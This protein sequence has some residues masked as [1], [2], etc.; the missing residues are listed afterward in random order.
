MIISLQSLKGGTGKSTIS[1]NLGIQ[2]LVSGKKVLA[3]DLDP[4]SSLTDFLLRDVD[5]ESISQ[6]NSFH[7]LS[8]RLEASD[9]IFKTETGIDAIPATP[10]LHKI[11]M[12]MNG[13]PG[14]LLRYK[15][16]LD[17]LGYDIV[18]IDTPPSLSY[19][20]RAGLYSADNVIVPVNYDRW[21]IQGLGLMQDEIKKAEKTKNTKM[22]FLAVP[23]MA[24]KKES[25]NL[26]ELGLPVSKTE[27]HR[28][29]SIRKAVNHGR[30][31]TENSKPWIQFAALAEELQVKVK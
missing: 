16:S 27:I 8:E 18:I 7:F 6:R 22:K 28:A 14:A 26:R 23:S 3:I 4:Q 5:I 19:E 20:F 12:E 9:C 29:L 17:A 10:H 1:L 13:D 21:I 31:L 2:F 30:L 15:R 24:T 25:E 11:G